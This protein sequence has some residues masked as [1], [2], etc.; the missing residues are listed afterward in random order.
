MKRR[1]S[2]E[3]CAPAVF[4]GATY[5][6]RA[7]LT[8]V[9]RWKATGREHVPAAGG[10]IFAANHLNNADPPILGAAVARRRLRFMAKVELF[11]LP[12]GVIP[13]MYGA[14]PVRRFGSDARALL[15]AERLL[16]DGQAL[17][18]FPEGTRSRTGRLGRA[19]PGTALIALRTGMP[20]VPCAITGTEILAN[21]LRLALR[22][23]FGVTIG[24]P[25][26]VE[27]RRRPTADEIAEASEAILAAIRGLLPP[28]YLPIYTDLDGRRKSAG[29][30]R[31]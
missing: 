24:K 17:G 18:M 2:W 9:V 23:R 11:K 21:P 8:L 1:L 5:A 7:L 15:T 30:S 22:P 31:Y 12:F 6:L 4:W 19:H 27:A 28:E 13:R 25:L 20:V 26:Q 29:Q 3:M 10:V 14:F 16:K